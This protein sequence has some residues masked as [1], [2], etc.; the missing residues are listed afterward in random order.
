MTQDGSKMA[1][2]SSKMAQ[3]ASKMPQKPLRKLTLSNCNSN[4]S[5]ECFPSS[6]A[7]SAHVLLAAPMV[8]Q[9]FHYEQ[10]SANAG[11]A[12][13]ISTFAF[14]SS[15]LSSSL[16]GCFRNRFNNW[17]RNS[18][19]IKS[20]TTSFQNQKHE[21]F[22]VTRSAQGMLIKGLQSYPMD[23]PRGPGD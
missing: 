23:T 21:E 6:G 15:R 10:W 19:P 3:D 4:H 16:V 22:I 11:G 13:Y 8:P 1:Q 18:G 20:R 12:A 9:G 5:K 17:S 2:D 14:M 7:G